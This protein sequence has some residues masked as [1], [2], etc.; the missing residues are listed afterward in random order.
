MSDFITL[1]TLTY[2]P[3]QANTKTT[4]Q[5]D[6]QFA[7]KEIGGAQ[8]TGAKIDLQYNSSLVTAYQIVNPDFTFDS[9]F[10]TE[11]AFVW[12]A[13]FD[14]TANLVGVSATGQITMLATS[15]SANPITVNEA[16]KVLT[17]KLVVTGQYLSLIHI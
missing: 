7:G 9:D 11:T 16:G 4:V 15:N 3:N 13:A 14:Q 12:V 8:V 2:T 1:G 5:F 10:G 17:V 6:I